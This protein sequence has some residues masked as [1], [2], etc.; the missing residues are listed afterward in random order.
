MNAS[1]GCP[2]ITAPSSFASRALAARQH[3]HLPSCQAMNGLLICQ[4]HG[5]RQ[6]IQAHLMKAAKC[7]RACRSG[8]NNHREI[9]CHEEHK[10]QGWPHE[11][12]FEGIGKVSLQVSGFQSWRG[13]LLV[14]LFTPRQQRRPEDI[15]PEGGPE[16]SSIVRLYNSKR[17]FKST[18]TTWIV[19][20]CKQL[21]RRRS[22]SMQPRTLR[23]LTIP[24]PY[25][26][27]HIFCR[28]V[29]AVQ[30]NPALSGRRINNVMP[31]Y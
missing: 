17:A 8:A 4:D 25:K 6:T 19:L 29:T 13:L 27:T 10:A 5:S 20:R 30:Q 3:R 7:S 23:R 9:H 24:Y 18:S 11:V 16:T 28:S 31:G 21:I 22:A 15:L 12:R 26:P 1:S 14:Q 2:P